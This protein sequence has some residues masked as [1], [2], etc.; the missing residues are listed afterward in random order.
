MARGRKERVVSYN[1][2]N[3]IIK[4]IVKHKK[5]TLEQIHDKLKGKSSF[6]NIRSALWRLYKDNIIEP[7]VKI[8][9]YKRTFSVI[10]SI[11]KSGD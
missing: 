6:E 4:E 1:L 7:H 5:L 3:Q 11:K 10:F 8:D 2:T 9:G